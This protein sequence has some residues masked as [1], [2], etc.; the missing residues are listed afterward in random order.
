MDGLTKDSLYRDMEGVFAGG[1]TASGQ[2]GQRDW[3]SCVRVLLATLWKL[4]DA[5]RKG[6]WSVPGGRFLGRDGK[7]ACSYNVWLEC[8]IKVW[9]LHYKMFY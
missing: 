9:Q 7:L 5:R 1:F 6:R 8:V 4:F 3:V 2:E